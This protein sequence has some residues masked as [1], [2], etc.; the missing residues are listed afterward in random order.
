MHLKCQWELGRPCPRRYDIECF[1]K[2]VLRLELDGSQG[3]RIGWR[4]GLGPARGG[5]GTRP[6]KLFVD[7]RFDP[8]K[9]ARVCKLYK[10]G[11][12]IDRL[13]RR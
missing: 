10:I 13:D 2:E 9:D 4:V 3:D 8:E 6:M 7:Q 12:S 5:D 1:Q 11:A